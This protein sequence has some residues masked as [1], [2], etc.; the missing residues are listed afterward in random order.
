V[1]L[2]PIVKIQNILLDFNK[3]K[4]QAGGLLLNSRGQ[5]CA[6]GCSGGAH[7]WSQ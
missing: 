5:P 3:L 2:I 6:A 7:R 4:S 1:A